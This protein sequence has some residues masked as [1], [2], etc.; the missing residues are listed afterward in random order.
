MNNSA[1]RR[2]PLSILA[3]ILLLAVACYGLLSFGHGAINL[4]QIFTHNFLT[5]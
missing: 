3:G 2:S 4:I 1:S 5:W